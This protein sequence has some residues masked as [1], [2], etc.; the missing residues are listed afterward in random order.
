MRGDGLVGA[1]A[2]GV[3]AAPHG[4]L[5]A[6]GVPTAPHGRCC[7]RG[8]SAA[9]L[10][11]RGVLNVPTAPHRHR[12]ARGV[13][14]ASTHNAVSPQPHTGTAVPVVS[15]QNS[16]SLRTSAT[17]HCCV[18]NVPMDANA[19]AVPPQPHTDIAVSPQQPEPH[20]SPRTWGSQHLFSIKQLFLHLSAAKSLNRKVILLINVSP[21]LLMITR[22][23]ISWYSA[24][25]ITWGKLGTSGAAL[26]D[27]SVNKTPCAQWFNFW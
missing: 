8:V 23:M 21:K 26:R 3:P 20:K 17:T 13:P 9:P 5:S 1:C 11:H 27:E 18:L 7:A 25:K 15:P 14:T 24:L 10:R 16:L 4:H 2:R 6:R 22:V 19:P 12:C